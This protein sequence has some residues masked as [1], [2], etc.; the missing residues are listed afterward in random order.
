MKNTLDSLKFLADEDNFGNPFKSKVEPKRPMKEMEF[1]KTPKKK[2]L[3]EFIEETKD[4][5]YDEDDYDVFD[6]VINDIDEFDEDNDLRNSLLSMGRKYARDYSASGESNEVTKAFAPQEAHLTDLLA[7]VSRETARLEDDINEM[8]KMRSRNYGKISELVEVKGSLYNNQLQILKELNSIKKT[9][10]DIKNK[11]K[12]TTSDGDS[13]AAQSVVQS[14]FGLGHDTLLAGVGGRDGSSGA[15]D[16]AADASY[17]NDE[18]YE[19]II[20]ASVDDDSDGAKFLKYEDRG[21]HYILEET[22]DGHR[23]VYAEDRDG[24]VID[25]YPVPKDVDELR[26]EINQKN[27]TAIDQLQRKYEYRYI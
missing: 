3:N 20:G 22:E 1:K 12:E 26:F 7:A 15:Y 2:K 14:I 17:D 24:N 8:R 27:N 21:A 9:Q 5:L 19:E 4:A 11:I 10:F 16:S 23:R 13:Y 25:D 18:A 6:D